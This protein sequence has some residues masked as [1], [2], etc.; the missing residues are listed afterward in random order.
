VLSV[1]IGQSA[2]STL[3]ANAA[4]ILAE[5]TASHPLGYVP[6]LQWKNLRVT[7]GMA[8]Y[9]KG[10]IALSRVLLT[11]EAR[12]RRTLVHEYAHL[13]A[14]ARHGR[15]AAGHGAAWRQ[16]ML[17]LGAEPEVTHKYEAKRNARRQQV[18]YRCKGCGASIVR[19]RRLPRRRKWVHAGCGG[20]VSLE[21][22]DLLTQSTRLDVEP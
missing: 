13:L 12:L 2:M 22:V 10:M 14:V 8:Y 4:A 11:D 19:A 3:A 1:E 6:V 20:A 21:S 7:A 9:T 5:L 15:K 17:E 16:A 18:T